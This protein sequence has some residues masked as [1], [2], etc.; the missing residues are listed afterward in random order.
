MRNEGYNEENGRQ[1][2][3][4]RPNGGHL[5]WFYVGGIRSQPRCE[6]RVERLCIVGHGVQQRTRRQQIYPSTL[7]S[8]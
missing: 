7:L 4:S 2:A 5:R 1:Q 8:H 3:D 6:V